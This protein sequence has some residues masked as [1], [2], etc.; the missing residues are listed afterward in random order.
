M[1]PLHTPVA[2]APTVSSALALLR[3]KFPELTAGVSNGKYAFWL[4]SGIS[5][6]RMPMLERI[7]LELLTFLQGLAENDKDYDLALDEVLEAAN[8]NA[9]V[10]RE[11]PP[12]KW[13]GIEQ[14]TKSMSDNYA[15]V[16]DVQVNGQPEDHL[17]W[18]GA[19]MV[20][21]FA[22]ESA[23]D[24][25]HI[26]LAILTLE[27]VAEDLVSANWDGL[28]EKAVARLDSRSTALKVHILSSDFRENPGRPQLIKFHGCAVKAKSDPSKY[29]GA[30]V[31]RSSQIER[32]ATTANSQNPA[33]ERV[34]VQVANE[35]PTLMLG[36]SAQDI[37]IRAVFIR[38]VSGQAYG[39][40][41]DK[42]AFIVSEPTL[43]QDQIEILKQVYGE[44]FVPNAAAIKGSANFPTFAKP[45]L[46][47]LVLDVLFSKLKASLSVSDLRTFSPVEVELLKRDLDNMEKAIAEYCEGGH[48]ARVLAMLGTFTQLAD[49]ARTGR[50]LPP[51]RVPYTPLSFGPVSEIA[52]DNNRTPPETSFLATVLAVLWGCGN[53]DDWEFSLKSLHRSGFLA[54]TTASSEARIFLAT[55]EAAALNMKRDGLFDPNDSRTVVIRPGSTANT[56]HRSPSRALGRS[57]TP[58]MREVG[59]TDLLSSSSTATELRARLRERATL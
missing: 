30:L 36:L 59:F 7:M 52:L 43:G 41:K 1:S 23:I 46:V 33:M 12:S 50:L 34:M 10:P 38:G 22:G 21:A 32:L 13:P 11:I 53:E 3:D 29:R 15:R 24:T 40:P 8:W 55:S 25:E 20:E 45:L 35:R 44:N 51:S 17:L 5:R 57:R 37:D 42:G 31:G 58:G 18:D 2:A 19:R 28:I 47:S 9:S 6:D 14:I 4:G 27:Q 16:L 56:P 48:L 39:W 49:L 54:V 26:C